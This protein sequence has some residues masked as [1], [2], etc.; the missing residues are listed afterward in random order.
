MGLLACILRTNFF[1]ITFL[2]PLLL[3]ACCF[4]ILFPYPFCQRSPFSG[5]GEDV[6][7]SQRL[8]LGFSAP[9][10]TYSSGPHLLP[11]S[12][13]FLL[14]YLRHTIRLQHIIYSWNIQCRYQLTEHAAAIL[15]VITS[16][17][18]DCEA[19]S[20]LQRAA[21]AATIHAEAALMGYAFYDQ[22]KE[23]SS[24]PATGGCQPQVLPSVL[25]VE[26][27]TQRPS[28]RQRFTATR[29][30]FSIFAL[31]SSLWG[32]DCTLQNLRI[33][34]LVIIRSRLRQE[35]ALS[36]MVGYTGISPFT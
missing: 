33:K 13:L 31:D 9:E 34:L 27:R 1:S 30:A 21:R 14:P 26:E 12:L 2:F 11:S 24:A 16:R 18:P 6:S 15:Q 22:S 29:N 25:V 10:T 19:I 20:A 5:V 7:A 32:S 4:A 36:G 28:H 8:A 35:R 3:F 17:K 23:I